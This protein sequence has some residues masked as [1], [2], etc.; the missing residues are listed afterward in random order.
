MNE[1]LE[2]YKGTDKEMKCYGGY[3]YEIGK[4]ETDTGAVR[5]EDK[6]FH[7]CEIPFDVL[8]YFPM[9]EGNRYFTAE[10]SGTVD[11]ADANDSKIASSELKIKAE[12]GI[13]GLIK[14]QTAYTKSK[15]ESGTNGVNGSN[16]AGGARS[17]LA[18]GARS[19]LAGGERSNLA[20]GARSNLVGGAGS[21][22]AG[23]AR[24]NLVGGE[25]SNLAGDARS[26]LAGGECSNLAG[27]ECSNLVG[28]ARS[29]L[30][31][32]AGSNLAGGARSNLAGGEWSNLAGGEWS[33]L[34]GGAH[35]NLAGGDS[36]LIVGRNGC[37]AKGGKNSVII[38]SEWDWIDNK[39]I[40][41]C[42][43]AEIV[44]GERI[45]AD[46]WYSLKNGQFVEVEE[47]E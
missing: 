25:W 19:N 13:A 6:G 8:R 30:A 16:L 35:S 32:G 31:G 42:I 17:N 46:T 43:K 24:S 47:Y 39:W 23:G 21:N 38:L 34:A 11:R 33:I 20:G 22:L 28:G 12:I 10:A 44:D 27:G 2:V 29:N 36:A 18:G 15:A 14:A 7:S 41:V 9:R 37:K 3:Q 45:K 40:P 4:Q 1:V 26:N 5:C